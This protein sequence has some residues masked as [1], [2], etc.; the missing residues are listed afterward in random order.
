[1]KIECLKYLIIHG[2]NKTLIEADYKNFHDKVFKNID[3]V[4]HYFLNDLISLSHGLEKEYINF[5]IYENIELRSYEFS[6]FNFLAEKISLFKLIYN[7]LKFQNIQIYR[8]Y[9]ILLVLTTIIDQLPNEGQLL[10]SN[11][12]LKQLIETLVWEK[13][14]YIKFN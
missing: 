5:K 6:T 9:V 4:Q 13:Q 1:M 11:A 10:L 7:F 2:S 14:I 3:I 12:F 8:N